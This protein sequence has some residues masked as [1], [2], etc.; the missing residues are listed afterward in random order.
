MNSIVA[1]RSRAAF[2]DSVTRCAGVPVVPASPREQ[3][4]KCT[5]RPPG[6]SRAITPPQPN[7]I[8][9]GC[10]PKAR[11]G[12]ESAGDFGMGFVGAV[13]RVAVDE[14]DFRGVRLVEI[15]LLAGARNVMRAMDHG[16]H[17]PQPRIARGR[18]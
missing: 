15:S 6:G 10:A 4:T 16:L 5:D 3:M 13:D 17:P 18:Y 14:R 12:G 9:S 1:P 11:R 8:S 2:F 7:S